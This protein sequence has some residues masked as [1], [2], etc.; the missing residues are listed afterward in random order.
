MTV[1]SSRKVTVSPRD[2]KYAAKEREDIGKKEDSLVTDF[3]CLPARR[4]RSF[5][6]AQM[7]GENL[8]TSW[9]A[10]REEQDARKG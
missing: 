8:E 3:L 2:E 4:R 5:A 9:A 6:R 1:Q 7:A 10:R